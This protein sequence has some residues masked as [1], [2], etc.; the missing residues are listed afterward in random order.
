M[1]MLNVEGVCEMG[2]RKVRFSSEVWKKEKKK[3]FTELKK[4]TSG[5]FASRL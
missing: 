1:C 2:L 4:F 3:K 5:L